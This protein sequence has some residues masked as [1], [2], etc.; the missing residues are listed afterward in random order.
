VDTSGNLFIADTGNGRIRKVSASGVITTAGGN[1]SDG[2]S[3]DGGHATSAALDY[4][5]GV[6]VD[7]SGNLVIW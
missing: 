1:G 3:S 6:A 2:F 5:H 4:P 7:A